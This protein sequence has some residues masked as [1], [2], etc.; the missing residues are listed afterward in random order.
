M[1]VKRWNLVL[2][3]LVL[4][5]CG[6]LTGALGTAIYYRH[7]VGHLFTEGQPGIRKLVMKKLV[8]ELDLTDVQQVQ[9]DKIVGE[10]QEN[11]R[12]FRTEHQP[13]IEAII[14]G[15]ISQMKPLLS[16]AQ[17][18]KLDVIFERLKRHWHRAEGPGHGR[19]WFSPHQ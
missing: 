4:F 1:P 12:K 15:G 10:V 9:I 5:I 11:L 17:Q 8:R 13:E 14:A 3:L 18:E 19:P 2:G 16:P 7:S 6:V